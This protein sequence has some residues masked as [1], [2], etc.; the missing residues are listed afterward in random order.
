MN[1]TSGQMGQICIA[2]INTLHKTMD[3]IDL[4]SLEWAWSVLIG[5]LCKRML[6]S[7]VF[8]ILFLSTE[9]KLGNKVI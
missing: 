5:S 6:S 4:T 8:N 2:M 9:I 1:G 7:A 3:W